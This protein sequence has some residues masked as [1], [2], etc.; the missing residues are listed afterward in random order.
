MEIERKQKLF[1]LVL[2]AVFVISVICAALLGNMILNGNVY[3]PAVRN[4]S[5]LSVFDA[6]MYITDCLMPSVVQ[7][8]FL[9]AS[10]FTMFSFGASLLVCAY[11]G[12]AFGYTTS[13]VAG[14]F[15][16]FQADN[17]ALLPFF[18]ISSGVLVLSLYFLST[19]A[20]ALLAFLSFSYAGKPMK[21]KRGVFTR[22][23]LYCFL[24]I[25]GVVFLADILKL[26]FISCM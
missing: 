6:V 7:L 24:L 26:L 19:A 14:G 2:S 15:L 23:Y 4:L 18:K 12:I 25:S 22:R 5:A 17:V 16:E 8:V 1:A 10:G 21:E 20:C 11:R 13:L 9:F 3:R